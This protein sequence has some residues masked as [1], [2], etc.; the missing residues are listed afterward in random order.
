MP[1]FTVLYLFCKHFFVLCS[2][3][4]AHEGIPQASTL[5]PEIEGD[6]SIVE[7]TYLR[8]ILMFQ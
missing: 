6:L 7:I 2:I 4:Y 5:V 1:S 3:T 8:K